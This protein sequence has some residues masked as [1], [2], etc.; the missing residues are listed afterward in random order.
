MKSRKVIIGLLVTGVI[1][2]L[3]LPVCAALPSNMWIEGQKQ[4][5]IEGSSIIQGRE[6]SIDVYAFGHSL[7]IPNDSQTGLPTGKRIHKP[8]KVLK[9]FDKSSP[10]LYLSLVTGERLTKVEIKFYRINQSGS[11]ENYFTILLEDAIIINI[12]PSMPTTLLQQ[13][14]T[15]RH[16]ETVSFSYR[17]I[18]WIWEPDG[19][20]ASDDWTSPK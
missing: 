2:L 1:I 6:G 3:S 18:T 4:G 19:I 14:E 5:K 8:F 12:S 7:Y 15:Y 17:K 16:M 20:G 9:T 13:N 11:E 10:K